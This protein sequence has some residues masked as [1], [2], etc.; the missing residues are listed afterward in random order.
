M[1]DISERLAQAIEFIKRNGY[2]K[3]RVEISKKLGVTSSTLSMATNGFRDPTVDL[4]VKLCDNYPINLDWLRKG[5]G[6][7][8]KGARELELLRRIDELENR[9]KELVK[10]QN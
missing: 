8:I 9:I 7:M 6:S 3:N 10:K 1:N 4:M 5:E 2:A